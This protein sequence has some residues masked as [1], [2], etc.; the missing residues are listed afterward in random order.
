MICYHI[1]NASCFMYNRKSRSWSYSFLE[2]KI[3]FL[4]KG[5]SCICRILKNMLDDIKNVFL[6]G[7]K[8]WRTKRNSSIVP[9]VSR[10]G[11]RCR[12]LYGTVPGAVT[13][14]VG[15]SSTTILPVARGTRCWQTAAKRPMTKRTDLER[16]CWKAVKIV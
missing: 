9:V 1:L 14:R 3:P 5:M 7:K 4:S 16:R 13:V 2:I 6:E 11:D 15:C 10:R 12:L 8:L